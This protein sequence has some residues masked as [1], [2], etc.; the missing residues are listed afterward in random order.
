MGQRMRETEG[1]R[2]GPPGICSI[3]S[4]CIK[5]HISFVQARERKGDSK[6]Y[7]WYMYR[8]YYPKGFRASAPAWTSMC[9]PIHNLLHTTVLQPSVAKAGQ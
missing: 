8:M 6:S 4:V 9:E 2:P 3:L 7:F 5:Y 1:G